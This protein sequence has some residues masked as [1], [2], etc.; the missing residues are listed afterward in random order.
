MKAEM[1]EEWEIEEKG[2]GGGLTCQALAPLT[3]PSTSIQGLTPRSLHSSLS[4]L[5]LATWLGINF[6]P[7]KPGFTAGHTQNQQESKPKTMNSSG[8]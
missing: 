7:P 3:P 4:F 1:K 5:I 8:A 6:C 2:G